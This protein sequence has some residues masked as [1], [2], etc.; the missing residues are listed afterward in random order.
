MKVDLNLLGALDA[1]LEEG[2][3]S[4]AADRLHLSAPAMSRTLTR[5]RHATGDQILVRTGRTMTPTPYALR[6]RER[7][8]GLVGEVEAVLAPQ[9]HLDLE[10]LTRTFTL[11][12]H[13]AITSAIGSIV[14]DTAR[15][16]APRVTL[17]LLPEGAVDTLDLKHG[18]VDLEIGSQAPDL[19]EIRS[20]TYAE[21]RLVVAMHPRNPLTQARLTVRRF[22]RADHLIVSRRGRLR[23]GID[24][25]LEERGLERHVVASAPTSTSALYFVSETNV[26]VVI[27]ARMCQPTVRL[28][29]LRTAEPPLALPP[30]PIVVSWHERYHSDLEHQWLRHVVRDAILR[31]TGAPPSRHPA[32]G[33]T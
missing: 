20:E 6:V 5:I 29:G 31:L 3:V 18:H 21:D 24:D 1:L 30:A 8:H 10:A 7:V 2:S 13:D 15:R 16:E 25:L 12:A 22:A 28:L 19:P 32:P 14:L 23:D 11:R 33:T 26:I 9:R 17:R 4:G 27:P